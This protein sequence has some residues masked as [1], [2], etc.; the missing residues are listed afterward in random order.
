MP[1]GIATRQAELCCCPHTPRMRLG[2]LGLVCFQLLP[3]AS[4]QQSAQW[5]LSDAVYRGGQGAPGTVALGGSWNLGGEKRSAQW[6]QGQ[7]HRQ[8][9]AGGTG[10]GAGGCGERGRDR[11]SGWGASAPG[12]W[13]GACYLIPRTPPGNPRTRGAAGDCKMSVGPWTENTN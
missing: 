13:L 2:R 10:Q 6:A 8:Y 1:V 4:R 12:Y 11:G 5:P 3:T 9:G 7:G